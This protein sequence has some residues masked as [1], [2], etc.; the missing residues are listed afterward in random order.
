MKMF[1]ATRALLIAIALAPLVD[2]ASSQELKKVNIGISSASLPAAAARITKEMG[3]FEKHGIDAAITWGDNSSIT[4]AGLISGSLD[5]TTTAPTEVILAFSRGQKHVVVKSLYAG[6][7]GVLVLS[8]PVAEKLGV[9]P[10]AP[11]SDRLKA[12]ND[13]VIATP[14][15]TS[16]FSLSL[17][18]SAEAVGGQDS[19]HGDVAGCHERLAGI[20]SYPGIHGKFSLLWRSGSQWVRCDVD[21]RPE[22]RISVAVHGREC[23]HVEYH[24]KF[25]DG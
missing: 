20:R 13:I 10:S 7:A 15:V 12:L 18:P 24:A 3:F 19:I 14:A 23:R 2:S 6:L 22:G 8:K 5:F 16:A 17:K 25:R 21:Q 9:S 1:S 4:T 11:V